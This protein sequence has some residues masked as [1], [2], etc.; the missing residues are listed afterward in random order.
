MHSEEI[1]HRDLKASNVLLTKNKV[2][3]LCDF[4]TCKNIANVN[5]TTFVGTY[6]YMAPEILNLLDKKGSIGGY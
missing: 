2:A 4:G 1:I 5:A 3:K 6:P